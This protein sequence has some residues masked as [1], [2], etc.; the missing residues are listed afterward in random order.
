MNIWFIMKKVVLY[1]RHFDAKV[2]IFEQQK[3]L[4]IVA[5]KNNWKIIGCF[6][7]NSRSIFF[8]KEV[9]NQYIELLKSS[10]KVPYSL[11]MIYDFKFI[12]SNASKV[13][14][15]INLLKESSIDLYFHKQNF[16]TDSSEGKIISQ[17]FAIF[18]NLKKEKLNKIKK[19]ILSA[20][21][22]GNVLGRPMKVVNINKIIR[23]RSSGMTLRELSM[24][25]KISLGKIHG[26]VK[27]N[28]M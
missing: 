16:Y 22:N 28:L 7:D 15:S 10:Y 6:N 14:D 11:I 2:S 8:H 3:H 26:I 4:K 27:D 5:K 13:F 12:V 20:H 18:S 17:I 23:D 9:N 24:K 1:I 19:G 25:H 21:K